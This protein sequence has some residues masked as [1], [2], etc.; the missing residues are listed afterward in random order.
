MQISKLKTIYPIKIQFYEKNRINFYKNRNS[1]KPITT[2]DF[3][4]FLKDNKRKQLFISE[5]K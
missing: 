3:R 4:Y 2:K 5:V 1:I